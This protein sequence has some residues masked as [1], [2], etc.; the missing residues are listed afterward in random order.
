MNKFMNEKVSEFYNVESLL[1]RFETHKKCWIEKE[2]RIAR[3]SKVRD[4]CLLKNYQTV[5]KRISV[6]T[7][8]AQNA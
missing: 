5:V 6:I 4:D 2:Y 1:P 8:H 7:L 3:L